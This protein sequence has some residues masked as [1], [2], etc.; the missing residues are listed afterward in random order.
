V[1]R[2]SERHAHARAWRPWSTDEFVR[3]LFT[4]G[5][6]RVIDEESLLRAVEASLRRFEKKWP[7]VN[8]NRLWNVSE[9]HPHRENVLSDELRDHLA[10]DLKQFVITREGQFPSAER[11]DIGIEVALPGEGHARLLLEVKMCDNV[12]VETAMEGQLANRYLREKNLTHGLYVV[13]WFTGPDWPPKRKP[14]QTGGLTKARKTLDEQARQLSKGGISI[15]ALVVDCR[16][17]KAP[18][19]SARKR[20]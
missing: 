6:T 15:G 9:S 20:Q 14:F 16:L 7:H 13:G 10:E 11:I 2:K 4:D 12:D 19:R 5:G 17:R 1:E 18:K 8:R 3:F